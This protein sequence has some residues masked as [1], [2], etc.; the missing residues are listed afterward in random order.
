MFKEEG[1]AQLD[2]ES[3]EGYIYDM[4]EAVFDVV[5]GKKLQKRKFAK[6]MKCGRLNLFRPKSKGIQFTA[7]RCNN[8]G[9]IISFGARGKETSISKRAEIFCENCEDD[10]RKCPITKLANEQSH[11]KRAK[12]GKRALNH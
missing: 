10:C 11:V 3:G 1:K 7:I 8:C 12:M 6:C 2:L 5:H 4:F 9:S